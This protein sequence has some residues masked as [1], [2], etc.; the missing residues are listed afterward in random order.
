MP[1]ATSPHRPRAY[2]SWLRNRAPTSGHGL[3]QHQQLRQPNI[4][5]ANALLR[6]A[7]RRATFWLAADF[8]SAAA[9]AEAQHLV[10]HGE[11]AE[12]MCVLAWVIVN[13]NVRVPARL[14]QDIRMFSEDLVPAEELPE[15]LSEHAIG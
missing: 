1:H 11:P 6:H 5:R 13:E 4:A 7:R 2:R 10:D 8:V 14:I 12:G 9:L 3:P 15:T